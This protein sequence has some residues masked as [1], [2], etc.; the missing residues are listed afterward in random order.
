[1]TSMYWR[2][3]SLN[4]TLLF[5]MWKADLLKVKTFWDPIFL[6]WQTSHDVYRCS[7]FIFV[8][9]F[10]LR[11]NFLIY[12]DL[13]SSQMFSKKCYNLSVKPIGAKCVSDSAEVQLSP[14]GDL[15]MKMSHIAS[16]KFEAI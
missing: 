14:F 4:S 9:W 8:I 5:S 12:Q 11:N 3:E 2:D 15:S 6:R 10:L 7:V 13:I 16:M 1:M